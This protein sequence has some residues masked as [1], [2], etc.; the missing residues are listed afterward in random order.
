[1][2]G[3]KREINMEMMTAEQAI[4]AARG[5]TFEKVW[6]TMME[7]RR[8]A[9]EDRK[10]W[11]KRAEED[12]REWKKRIADLS[13]NLGGLGNS[14]GE[15]TESM[16]RNELRKKFRNI[17]IPV[18]S[19]SC[20]KD[21]SDHEGRILAEV[22][23]FMENGEYAIAVEIKT[24]MEIEFVKDHL[25][26]IEIVRRHMDERGDKRKLIGA[27][28][29]GTVPENVMKYAH[30]HGLYVIAQNGDS[31]SIADAPKGFKAREW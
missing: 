14:I 17:G 7:D 24:K 15:F 8:R 4:E 5:L 26:R 3:G 1:M 21:F 23:I 11:E 13:K 25:K 27:I 19:Q 28:V 10:K 20:Y 22:D 9:E 12:R 18:T 6:A 29:G 31:V 16:F 30:K 2:I